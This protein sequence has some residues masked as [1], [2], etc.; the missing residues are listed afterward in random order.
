[1]RSRHQIQSN[2]NIHLKRI[3]CVATLILE[4]DRFGESRVLL[5][6]NADWRTPS[7]SLPG[8]AREMGESLQDAALRE[9]REETGLEVAITELIDVHEIIGVG[10][11]VHLVI[12]TFEAQAT[13]GALIRDGQ[14]E[15]EAGGVS[16]ARWFPLSEAMT[17]PAVARVL[18]GVKRGRSV[19]CTTDRRVNAAGSFNHGNSL[20]E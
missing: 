2:G 4:G 19:P 8:G 14:G 16:E 17:F 11:R 5:V 3:D 15:P 10:G 1:M 12:F 20:G 13:G 9:V 7:W 6:W 18:K